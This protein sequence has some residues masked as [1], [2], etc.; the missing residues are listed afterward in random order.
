VVGGLIFLCGGVLA[1][2]CSIIWLWTQ[3]QNRFDDK[4][5]KW[6]KTYDKISDIYGGPVAAIPPKPV[7]LRRRISRWL[8]N[9]D[10]S[11]A[12]DLLSGWWKAFHTKTCPMIEIK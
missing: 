7:R 1:I 2:G 9:L 3:I 5:E 12:G 8:G 11:W 4:V 10:F 6:H